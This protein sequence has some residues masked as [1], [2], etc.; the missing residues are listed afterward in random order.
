MLGSPWKVIRNLQKLL[1]HFWKP[2]SHDKVT[3]SSIWLRKSRQVFSSC[4]VDVL[5]MS[6]YLYW[7]LC[8]LFRFVE[9]KLWISLIGF[10]GGLLVLIT[11]GILKR[12]E[13]LG[14]NFMRWVTRWDENQLPVS[15]KLNL[16]TTANLGTEEN[17][18]CK[19]EVVV[20]RFQTRVNVTIFCPLVPKKVVVVERWPL[21]EV[22]L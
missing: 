7:P 14:S 12:A 1:R 8:V 16:S 10:G 17:V 19:E 13:N 9:L 2:L 4:N 3:I 22:Q 15:I 21:A 20:L 5:L 18:S 6:M 11:T